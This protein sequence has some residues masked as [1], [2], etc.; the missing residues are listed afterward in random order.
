[1]N[2]KA[3]MLATAL[4]VLPSVANT[5]TLHFLCSYHDNKQPLRVEM[6]TKDYDNYIIW[7]GEEYLCSEQG[8]GGCK[9][10][11][12]ISKYS[13]FSFCGGKAY[14]SVDDTKPFPDQW[15]C[16]RRKKPWVPPE[17]NDGL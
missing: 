17:H 8:K 7:Q 3:L 15:H 12:S 11:A 13:T 9:F 16:V 4:A 1:M 6:A 10:F 2:T 14:I 5:A